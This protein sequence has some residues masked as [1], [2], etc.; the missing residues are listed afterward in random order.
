MGNFGDIWQYMPHGMCLLWQPWL[1]ILWAGSDLLIFLSY[2]AIPIALLTVLRKRKD[3]PHSGL[4]ML[5]ASFI[6]LCGLTHLLSIVTLWIP[7]YPYVGLVKLAT[8]IVSAVTAIVLFG[9]IPTLASLPSPGEL[10][11][12]N[13]KLKLEAAAHKET[14]AELRA[15]GDNLEQ[16]VAQRTAELSEANSKLA[17]LTRE[18]VHRSS[19]LLTV[20]TA[21]ARQNARATNDPEHFVET[22]V[23]RLG[24]LSD[25]TSSVLRGDD[26]ASQAIETIIRRQLEP[27]TN[28]VA[29]RVSI[30]GPTIAISSEAAQQLSLAVHELATNAQKYGMLDNEESRIQV[31]WHIATADDG[32]DYFDLV[33]NEEL[34]GEAPRDFAVSQKEGF[35]TKL[36]TRIVPAVLRGRAERKFE[37]DRFFYHLHAPLDAI[38]AETDENS[39]AARIV[40]ETFGIA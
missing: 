1:V 39:L 36:L 40:D 35:G 33:W 12:S 28:V 22:F 37:T 25:A 14:L 19:N 7:I 38:L 9:L 5:F 4:V 2:S 8:G 20:V 34:V 26:S 13:D 27:L 16:Q 32:A 24:A 29:D 31:T 15:A 30:G 3:V 6:L 18:A 21:L 17:V 11:E 23:G 10:K